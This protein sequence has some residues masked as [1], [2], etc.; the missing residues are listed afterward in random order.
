MPPITQPQGSRGGLITAL[1]VFAILFL[2]AAIF[3]I[4]FNV[5]MRAEQ[6]KFTKLES[7]YKGVIAD[8]SLVAESDVQTAVKM[9][10]DQDPAL[11]DPNLKLVDVLQQRGDRLAKVIAGNAG[12]PGLTAETEAAARVA[13]ANEKIRAAKLG[14][15]TVTP[16]NLLSSIDGLVKALIAKDQLVTSA[17]NSIT[18]KFAD[19]ADAVNA[20]QAKIEAIQQSVAAAQAEA[21]KARA[22][23]AKDR[24]EKQAQM[25]A[26]SADV[27][28]TSDD[29][30]KAVQDKQLEVTTL[31]GKQAKLEQEIDILKKKLGQYRLNTTESTVRRADGMITGLGKGNTVYVNLGQGQEVVAGMTFEVYD[32]AEGVPALGENGLRDDEMPI[33]KGSIEIVRVNAA[34]SEC[35]VVKTTPGFAIAE[36]DLI[37]NLV[38]DQNIKFKFVVY[39]K[40]DLD[41]NGIATDGDTDV[42]KRLVTQWG[43][44][45]TDTVNADTDFVIL[46]KEPVL[47]SFSKEELDLP[48]NAKK[49]ADA[50]TEQDAYQK[51]KADARE[52]HIPVMNQNRFLYFVG[53]YDQAKR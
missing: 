47:P 33:G 19:N 20:S 32:K 23:L 39:G 12:V 2:T 36:G 25:D 48:E 6:D 18:K 42:M 31:Q 17:N 45:V 44:K 24:S 49:L 52:L 10:R 50:Q 15:V 38:Y 29:L 16:D 53:Y 34:N 5:N 3:A 8:G 46:G 22:E 7:K 14:G 26:M 41:Q 21:E 1:V 28:K 11:A 27:K 37:A 35:R 51:V 30:N 43:G 4:Y 40:Y 9:L 13:A